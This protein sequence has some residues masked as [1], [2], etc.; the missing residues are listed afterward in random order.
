MKQFVKS[1]P[2]LLVCIVCITCKNEPSKKDAIPVINNPNDLRE[3]ILNSTIKEFDRNTFG[4][5]LRFIRQRKTPI[6]LYDQEFK[7][8]VLVSHEYQGRVL[9]STA[10]G[11]N[12]YS[13][14]WMNYDL[15]AGD[16]LNDHMNAFGGEDRVWL[17]PEGGQYSLYF[18]PNSEFK[19]D[20]WQVPYAFDS[21][22]FDI[23]SISSEEVSLFKRMNLTNYANNKL[24]IV[25]S[26]QVKLES[27]AA[28]LI[29]YGVIADPKIKSVGFS[30]LNVLRNQ[31]TTEWN[32]QTGM[33]S[34]WIL[35]MFKP[36]PTAT[37]VLPYKPGPEKEMGKAV[38]DDYFGAIPADRMIVDPKVVYFKAD[39]RQRG[40]IGTNTYR[41]KNIAGCFDEEKGVLTLVEFTLP[42]T[43]SLYVNSQWKIQDKPFAG[44]VVNAYNDGPLENGTQLG[45]FFEIETSSPAAALKGGETIR[46]THAT[47]HFVGTDDQ[48]NEIA[49]KTLGVSIAEIR[50]AF[51]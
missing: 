34:I 15:I 27:P 20:N 47:Y 17:G 38:N 30:S 42:D 9:T 28:L 40:K 22:S 16:N 50:N 26:R 2:V 4:Y 25:L 5:D 18:K 41:A 31:G 13:F 51:K 48:L 43:P 35:G 21:E 32:Q 29:K 24:D 10:D 19:Y 37:V 39:G 44:D 8:M 7:R 3:W 14:G 23:V 49:L 12:G 36:S 33:P 45:P 46:H 11:L 1:I 6:L